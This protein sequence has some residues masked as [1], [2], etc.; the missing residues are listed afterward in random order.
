MASNRRSAPPRPVADPALPE[1]A[2]QRLLQFNPDSQEGDART[3]HTAWA[4]LFTVF[5]PVPLRWV[6]GAGVAG[7]GLYLTGWAS[8]L[9]LGAAL[10][11]LLVV[12]AWVVGLWALF[13]LSD[14]YQ[15]KQ[16]RLGVD[17]HV[18][19]DNLD[20]RARKQLARA[21]RAIDDVLDSNVIKA[22][23]LDAVHNKIALPEYEWK[24]ARALA[25]QTALR[26]R[27]PE[28]GT[29]LDTAAPESV[30]AEFHKAQQETNK[31]VAALEEYA[32]RVKLAD[33]RYHLAAIHDPVGDSEMTALLD[34]A[35]IAAGVLLDSS[36]D[37]PIQPP[38]LEHR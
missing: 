14:V 33:V 35:R 15:A 21:Q 3:R 28:L 4:S 36:T 1:R 24:I 8:S 29:D 7:V 32:E 12:L 19:P 23:W 22:G 37:S 38:P 17:H 16:H 2:R 11:A 6:A 31:Q 20:K 13:A 30:A 27:M 25:A 9:I 10:V 34:Q 26:R 5:I 18:N